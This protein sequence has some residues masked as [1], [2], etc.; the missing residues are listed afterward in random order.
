MKEKKENIVLHLLRFI[1]IGI[2]P[3][4]EKHSV[5]LH[6]LRFILLWSHLVFI[7]Y[8]L[9]IVPLRYAGVIE[10]LSGWDIGNLSLF[11]ISMS[12]NIWYRDCPLTVW[13][14]PIDQKLGNPVVKDFIREGL[15]P[16]GIRIPQIIIYCGM[17]A[18][19]V[20]YFAAYF[21]IG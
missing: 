1:F 9:L 5:G 13:M 11:A 17:V 14:K 3:E 6:F 7:A 19:P 2:T 10:G 12:L 16:Y 15:E 4:E 20:L 18:L 21:L 8:L